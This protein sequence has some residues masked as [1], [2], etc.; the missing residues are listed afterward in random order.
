VNNHARIPPSKRLLRGSDN[1]NTN[2]AFDKKHYLSNPTLNCVRTTLDSRSLQKLE[3]SDIDLSQNVSTLLNRFFATM[4]RGLTSNEECF[5]LTDNGKLLDVI[6]KGILFRV[7]IQNE[8]IQQFLESLFQDLVKCA[9]NDLLNMPSF[10]ISLSNDGEL[11]LFKAQPKKITSD[12][13]KAEEFS[14]A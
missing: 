2:Q 3:I 8:L 12:F 9:E 7:P 11:R 13:T 1:M 4:A 10:Y 5:K 14:P 6:G